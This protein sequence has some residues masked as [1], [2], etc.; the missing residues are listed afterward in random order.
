MLF[1]VD[2]DKGMES[3]LQMLPPSMCNI[4][5]LPLGTIMCKLLNTYGHE[6]QYNGTIHQLFPSYGQKTGEENSKELHEFKLYVSLCAGDQRFCTPEY[7]S[8]AQDICLG[9]TPASIPYSTTAY[10]LTLPSVRIESVVDLEYQL[11]AYMHAGKQNRIDY[12]CRG[13]SDVCCATLHTLFRIGKVIKKCSNCG[14]FFIPKHRSDTMFCENEAPQ[15]PGRTCREY[16]KA[17]AYRESLKKSESMSLYRNAY[18]SKQM[19]AKRNPDI[20]EYQQSFEKYKTLSKQWK[21]D[22]KSG[23]RTEEEYIAW[24]KTVKEKKVL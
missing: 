9:I 20:Q 4:G 19:L 16:G 11:I 15:R 17:E 7:L 5:P 24:L 3:C 12:E 23:V 6:K 13:P 22:V 10:H 18:M 2:L 14:E 21:L 1:Q 8:A